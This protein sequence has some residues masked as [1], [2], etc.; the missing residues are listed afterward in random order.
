MGKTQKKIGK[1][2]NIYFGK[3]IYILYILGNNLLVG[4]KNIHV[5]VKTY[6]LG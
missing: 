5:R 6:M 3:V 4:G 2:S 1:V